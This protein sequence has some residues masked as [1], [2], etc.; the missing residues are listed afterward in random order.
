LYYHRIGTPQSAD[1]LVVEFPEEPKWRMYTISHLCHN[2]EFII[3]LIH[4]DA[5]VSEC[6]NYL[7]ITPQKDCRDNL[8]YFANIG[9]LKDGPQGILPLQQIVDKF[10]A[11]YEV[12][13]DSNVVI[14]VINYAG[15]FSMS[16][17]LGQSAFSVPIKMP[18]TT[19][20][21][22]SIWRIPVWTS[23]APLSRK[24]QRT[25]LT[26]LSMCTE[27]NL[28]CAIFMMSK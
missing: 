17:T 4:R 16:R 22:A 23:G 12:C 9:S 15:L 26:G 18:P 19:D 6:G 8:L 13:F 27:I 28:S 1:V 11:D 14:P 2:I 20:W 21:S 25:C 7:L 24:I 10:E 5:E 3:T